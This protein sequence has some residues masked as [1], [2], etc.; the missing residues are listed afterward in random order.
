LIGLRPLPTLIR[1]ETM[2]RIFY[3][4]AAHPTHVEVVHRYNAAEMREIFMP[5]EFHALKQGRPVMKSGIVFVN[6]MAAAMAQVEEFL[7][8]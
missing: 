3:I 8:S 7:V 6:M 1:R 5:E 2:E 4:L